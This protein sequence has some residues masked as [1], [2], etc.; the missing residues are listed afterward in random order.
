[1]SMRGLISCC[2][3]NIAITT[4]IVA[5]PLL[6]SA[7]V[8]VDYSRLTV[9]Q[10]HL[11]AAVDS[12]ALAAAASDRKTEK[13][14]VA[15]AKRAFRQNMSSEDWIRRFPLEV[16]VGTDDTVT[17]TAK[18]RLNGS[19]MRLAGF[20]RMDV[21]VKASAVRGSA[22]QTREVS[23]VLDISGSMSGSEIAALKLGANEFVRNLFSA[24]GDVSVSVVPYKGM[25]NIGTR[26]T[27]W[28]TQYSGADY[29]PGQWKG[30]VDSRNSPFDET[31]DPPITEQF[32]PFIWESGVSAPDG[33]T[34]I[35]PQIVDPAKTGEGGSGPNLGCHPFPI[36]PLTRNGQ[37]VTN[38]I[39]TLDSANELAGAGGGGT[40]HAEGLAWGWRTISPRWS[41]VWRASANTK[42]PEAYSSAEKIVVIMTDGAP[43]IPFN[44]RSSYGFRN[45]GRLGTGSLSQRMNEK[46]LRI[47]NALKSEGIKIFS[48][49]YKEQDAK[50]NET[51]KDC[52]DQNG[53]YTADNEGE[54]ANVLADMPTSS[55]Q[56][57]RL[58]E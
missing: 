50:I 18:G 43:S 10:T 20:S 13:Q 36:L 40:N 57:V 35:W 7:G 2:T 52:A 14:L 48:V 6:I 55:T 26:N 4:A 8:A 45:E 11:Q 37:T 30:C 24:G 46:T 25:V 58:I 23:L 15:T 31:D 9:A 3:G 54:L 22:S 51:F 17:V 28:L 56:T 19:L 1:M 42:K 39:S 33:R 32:K 5:V 44:S 34:N 38:Y 41:G 49:V 27:A 53:F 29:L 12:A 21:E 16:V 47:C